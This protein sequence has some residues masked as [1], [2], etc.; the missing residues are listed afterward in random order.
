MY[1]AISVTLCKNQINVT[2]ASSFVLQ[3]LLQHTGEK[4]SL[5]SYVALRKLWDATPQSI[6][7]PLDT[8]NSQVLPSIA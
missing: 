4:P 2:F 8:E 3:Q 1:S 7:P 6:Y 5:W